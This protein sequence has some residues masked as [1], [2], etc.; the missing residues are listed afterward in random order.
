M[1]AP[2]WQDEQ[3][4]II[5]ETDSLPILLT[6]F[7]PMSKRRSPRS[8]VYL[9]MR[10]PHGGIYIVTSGSGLERMHTDDI[11][12]ADCI[13]DRFGTWYLTWHGLSADEEE[14]PTPI[15]VEVVSVDP[16]VNDTEAC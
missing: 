15:R 6:M 16:L 7:S 13:F 9:E 12:V 4:P 3:A 11:Y 8:D 2:R 5:L 14:R 10:G 1:T